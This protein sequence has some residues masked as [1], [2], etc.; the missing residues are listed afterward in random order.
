MPM[1]YCTS[2]QMAEK[3][4]VTKRRVNALCQEG[5][6]EIFNPWSVLNCVDIGCKPRTFWQS[7]G[8]NEIIGEIMIDAPE[9]LLTQL[10]SLLN[11]ESV[12]AYINTSVVYPE[13]HNNP[14]SVFSFLLMSGYLTTKSEEQLFDGNSFCKVC[15]PNREISF[16]YEK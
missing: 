1:N 2:L 13:I 11:E 9:Q 5:L 4:G 10:R 14:E 6:T 3:W 12:D 7:T 8:N 15:I 16:V